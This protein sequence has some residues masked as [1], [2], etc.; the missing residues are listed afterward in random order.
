MKNINGFTLIELMIVVA[1][2]AILA[3]V[4][5]PAYN[6]Y[7]NRARMAE[8]ILAA[9]TLRNCVT[10]QVQSSEAIDN[11]TLALCDAPLNTTEYVAS[12][13]ATLTDIDE[14]TITATA[15][16]FASVTQPE[17]LMIGSIAAG[18]VIEWECEGSANTQQSW[19]PVSCRD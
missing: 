14:V 17:I 15:R 8:V 16:N 3:A 19:L 4:A 9:S 6:D 5:I 7:S 11:T 13:V 12:V 10:E 18:N 1:I 2:I